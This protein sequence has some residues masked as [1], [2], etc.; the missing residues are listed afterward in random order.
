MKLAVVDAKMASIDMVA[1]TEDEDKTLQELWDSGNFEI[2]ELYE[3]AMAIAVDHGYD[4]WEQ[5][6]S[7]LVGDSID[8]HYENDPAMY[9]EL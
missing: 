8:V 9:T 7:V 6:K 4:I 3:T 2:C 1:L 5:G